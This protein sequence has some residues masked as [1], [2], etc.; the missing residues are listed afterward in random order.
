MCVEGKK[1]D[2]LNE[3]L[4]ALS[5]RRGQLKQV[6]ELIDECDSGGREGGSEVTCWGMS[7]CG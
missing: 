2:L 7:G 3:Q 1:W 4:V 6:C 5:K